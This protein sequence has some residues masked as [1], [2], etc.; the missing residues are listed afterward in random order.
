[1]ISI[2]IG[3][4]ILELSIAHDSCNTAGGRVPFSV[5]CTRESMVLRRDGLD[6]DLVRGTVEVV[7]AKP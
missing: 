2:A 4:W 1:M 6:L 5:S 3:L 7:G